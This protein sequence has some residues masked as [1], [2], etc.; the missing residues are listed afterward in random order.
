MNI[1]IPTVIVSVAIMMVLWVA[2]P[3]WI[4]S[5]VQSVLPWAGAPT[6]TV[7]PA[8]EGVEIGAVWS[9]CEV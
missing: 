5:T 2:C 6:D 9:S 4:R 3:D 1:S 7:K 8:A